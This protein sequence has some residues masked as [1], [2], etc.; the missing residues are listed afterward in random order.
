MKA[1]SSYPRTEQPGEAHRGPA[2]IIGHYDG[3]HPW[4]ENGEDATANL[5]R[6]A[7]FCHCAVEHVE[8]VEEIDGCNDDHPFGVCQPRLNNSPWTASHSLRSSPS[9]SFTARRRFPEPCW[10]SISQIGSG[11]GS[12]TSVASAYFLS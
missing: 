8:V 11:V 9:G 5:L 3:C 7:K 2:D 1:Q 12:L 10:M 6:G 4:H